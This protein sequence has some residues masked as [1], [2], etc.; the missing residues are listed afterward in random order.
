MMP[1]VGKLSLGNF[2]FDNFLS[3]VNIQ[4]V[5]NPNL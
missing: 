5:L 1:K 4:K 2:N 3:F